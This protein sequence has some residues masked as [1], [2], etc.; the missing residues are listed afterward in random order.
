MYQHWKYSIEYDKVLAPIELTFSWGKTY[1]KEVNDIIKTIADSDK[2]YEE[3]IFSSMWV[4][5]D[6][7]SKWQDKPVMPRFEGRVYQGEG[8]DS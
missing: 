2:H 1:H 5:S 7:K 3:N 4:T 6:L 8:T